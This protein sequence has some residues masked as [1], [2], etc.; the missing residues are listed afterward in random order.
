MKEAIDKRDNRTSISSFLTSLVAVMILV[1]RITLSDPYIPLAKNTQSISCLE[2]LRQEYT[3]VNNNIRHYSALRFAIFPVYFVAFGGL[4]SIAFSLFGAQSS[5]S[6]FIK[7]GARIGGVL[8]TILF[9]HYE[10]LVEEV[11]SKNRKRGQELEKLLG[12]KQITSRSEK[13]ISKSIYIVRGLYCILLL[14]W[15]LMITLSIRIIVR[16]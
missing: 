12:Y 8:I 15:L 13:A 14:F 16:A 9:F 7:L 1:R 2:G 10:Y 11:L 4:I 6:D 5:N 3:E